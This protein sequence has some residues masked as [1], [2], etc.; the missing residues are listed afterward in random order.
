MRDIDVR[1]ALRGNLERAHGHE[2]DTRIID[3]LGLCQG[4]A[5]VDIAVINGSLT[6]YEIKSEQ[7]TLR[8]LD[9]QIELY[10]RTLDFVQIVVAESH[11]EATQE[12]VPS[13]WGVQCALES[14]H[15]VVIEVL[16]PPARNEESDPAAIVQLLW[17]DEVLHL[18]REHGLAR[19]LESKPRRVLWQVLAEHFTRD[20]LSE[21][22]RQCLKGRLNWRSD[23]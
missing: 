10:N 22:V 19:G 11:L 20:E 12:R 18:L 1:R 4:L 13:W 16:R 5:R 3:E 15:G 17:R 9:H 21:H 7:D 2:R 6:G 23:Q 8:R 14:R